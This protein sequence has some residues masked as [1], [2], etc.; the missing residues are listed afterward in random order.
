MIRNV[1]SCRCGFYGNPIYLG[2]CSKCYKELVRDA[3]QDQAEGQSSTPLRPIPEQSTSAS[4]GMQCVYGVRVQDVGCVWMQG[5]YG[6]RVCMDGM[7]LYLISVCLFPFDR[8]YTYG[9]L[10]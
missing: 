4:P 1:A 6:C 5:V 2:Y 3:N 9:W 10:P 7:M 8:H